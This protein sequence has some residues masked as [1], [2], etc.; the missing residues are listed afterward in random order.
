MT[1]GSLSRKIA[2]SWGGGRMSRQGAPAGPKKIAY[3][4][5]KACEILHS[6]RFLLT[7]R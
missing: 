1:R 6:F 3:L 5:D 2:R 7:T 4:F